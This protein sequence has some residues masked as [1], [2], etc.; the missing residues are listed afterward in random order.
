[1]V[2]Q[3]RRFLGD[4]LPR[5]ALSSRHQDED[6]SSPS[7]PHPHCPLCSFRP[8]RPIVPFISFAPY[9]PF[10]LTG[11][12]IP[13]ELGQHGISLIW[14][15]EGRNWAKVIFRK[16]LLHKCYSNILYKCYSNR[17]VC[18]PQKIPVDK[19]TF[20]TETLLEKLPDH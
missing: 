2:N 12:D 17:V 13:S 19:R 5:G 20:S 7:P 9:A 18:V 6:P 14:V 3:Q 10:H 8:P 1:M 16:L 4:P 15:W 11:P